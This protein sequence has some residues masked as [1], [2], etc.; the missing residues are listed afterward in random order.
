MSV[1]TR[2]VQ[3]CHSKPDGTASINLLVEAKGGSYTVISWFTVFKI[4]QEI[5]FAFVATIT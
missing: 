5:L 4:L 3:T 1:H 2:V